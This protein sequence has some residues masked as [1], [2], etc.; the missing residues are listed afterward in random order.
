MSLHKLNPSEMLDLVWSL[1]A[2][3]KLA[4]ETQ[5]QLQRFIEQEEQ[6]YNIVDQS[7]AESDKQLF[8]HQELQSDLK[9]FEELNTVLQ[10]AL[11]L[12]RTASQ[13]KDKV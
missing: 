7:D 12:L 4:L 6:F 9:G 2:A 8:L 10:Q 3:R 5:E 1:N 11:D 13:K